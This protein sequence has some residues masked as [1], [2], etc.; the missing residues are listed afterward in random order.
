VRQAA[1]K[2][3]G[4]ATEEFTALNGAARVDVRIAEPEKA[5][6][7]SLDQ[8]RLVG[9]A[10]EVVKAV[11]RGLEGARFSVTRLVEYARRFPNA[12]VAARLGY[13]L[14]RF[15]A[16][17]AETELLQ[18]GVRRRGPA[19]YLAVLGHRG[20]PTY[21]QRWHLLVNVPEYFFDPDM[22]L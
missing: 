12:A 14:E 3:Y 21:D 10:T 2:F 15:G 19:P 16:P 13:L 1:A 18:P 7:D 8:E 5:V 9:G 20:D 11:R 22:E 6:I 4:F 17:P